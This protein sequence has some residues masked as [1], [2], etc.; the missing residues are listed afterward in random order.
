LQKRHNLITLKAY[1][2]CL[3]FQQ[4]KK[5]MHKFRLFPPSGGP[6]AGKSRE[7]LQEYS[8]PVSSPSHSL[9]PVKGNNRTIA[10]LS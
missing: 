7:K 1:Q 3:G 9:N 10:P 8:H 4:Y 5:H 2:G 6:L